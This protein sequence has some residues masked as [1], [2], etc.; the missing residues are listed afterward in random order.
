MAKE[1]ERVFD[2]LKGEPQFDRTRH[3]SL[4]DRGS[5]DSYYG[6]PRDPHWWPQG[7]GT[8]TKIENLTDAERR[9]YIAGY[10]HNEQFGMKKSWV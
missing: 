1:K 7:T 2:I 6:R 3:G 10:D 8:G 4:W 5:A 9:E